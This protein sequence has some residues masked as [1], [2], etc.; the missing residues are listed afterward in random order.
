MA[1]FIQFYVLLFCVTQ[2]LTACNQ[3]R[4]EK[5]MESK[6]IESHFAIR[7]TTEKDIP[8]PAC[9]EEDKGCAIDPTNLIPPPIKTNSWEICKTACQSYS[10]CKYF[11]WYGPNA[12]PFINTCFL[13][14]KKCD[15]LKSLK[16]FVI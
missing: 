14:Q 15:P 5:E 1:T 12:L 13:L 16:W 11:V 4:P 3:P 8:V 10:N 7:K 2:P 6:T 9:L